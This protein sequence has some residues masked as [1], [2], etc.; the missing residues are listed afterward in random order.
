MQEMFYF[1]VLDKVFENFLLAN[2]GFLVMRVMMSFRGSTRLK[3][4]MPDP[5]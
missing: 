4:G 3:S 2:E 1:Q 5:E